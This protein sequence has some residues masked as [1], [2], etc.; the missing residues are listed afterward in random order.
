[1]LSEVYSA[2]AIAE[3]VKEIASHINREFKDEKIIHAV[4]TLN[5]SFMFAADLIRHVKVPM[6]VHFAGTASYSGR[7]KQ[8]LR[9]NPDAFPKSFGNAP[10]IIIEDIVDSGATIKQLRTLMAER[11]ASHIKVASLLRRQ[12][13]NADPDWFGFTVPKNLF[14]VGYGMDMD[15]R[16]RELPDLKAISAATT[17][18]LC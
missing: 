4:V 3:R 6:E 5:G 2:G 14:V 15:G 12:G 7:E 18:G 16:F 11:F 9:I 1:M 13:G 8:D 10:V 17:S